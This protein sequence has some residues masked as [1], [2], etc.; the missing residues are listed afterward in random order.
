VPSGDM[1]GELS[2]T[3]LEDR[4]K[5]EAEQKIATVQA[6][7]EVLRLQRQAVS[8]KL[9][10]LRDVEAQMRVIDE[11]DRHLSNCDLGGMPFIIAG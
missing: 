9:V 5:A 4:I 2:I 10:R 6:E 1:V 8:L 7:A 11:W 3:D